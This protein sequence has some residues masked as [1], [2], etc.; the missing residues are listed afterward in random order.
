M[1]AIEAAEAMARGVV[2]VLPEAECTL[3]PMADGGEGTTEVLVTALGGCLIR[4]PCHDALGRHVVGV[5]GYVGAQSLAIIEAASGCGL[6][7]ISSSDRNPFLASS[8]GVGELISAALDLGARDIILGLGGSATNDA[9]TG[10]L[11][12]LGARFLTIEGKPISEGA[13]GLAE[14]DNADFSGL[15]P[16]LGR[17]RLRMACDV[18][19]PLVGPNGASAIFGPQK[20]ARPNDIEPLDG[21]IVRWADVVEPSVHRSVR[22]IPGSGAAGGMSAG[23]LAVTQATMSRGIDLVLEAVN[24]ESA[25]AGAD[26]VFTGEGSIDHQTSSGKTPWGVAQ[27]AFR[28]GTRSVLF[29]GRVTSDAESLIGGGIVA[30]IPILHLVTD[31]ET[32]LKE[33]PNNLERSTAMIVRLLC[34]SV[35]ERT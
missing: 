22:D 13:A 29:G 20:G 8:R 17:V 10:L 27:A 31:L 35:N 18:S 32:A 34:A 33:G 11:A 5:V 6:E 26:W 1:T 24:F 7:Q 2:S 28:V 12:A 3:M 30:L 15:D 14:L 19:N 23:L 21:A 4:V 25:A 9:G 16:R